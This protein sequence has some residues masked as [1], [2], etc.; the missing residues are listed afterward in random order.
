[1]V[2]NLQAVISIFR[3]DPR[4]YN[5]ISYLV[6]A[7]LLV[8]WAI[9]TLRHRPTPKT[10]SLALAAIAALSMLPIYHREYDTK[11]LLLTVPACAILWAEGGRIGRLALLVN[12]AGFVLTG[13]LPNAAF[14]GFLHFLHLPTTGLSGQ[15]LIAAQVFP[16]PLML[17][18]MGIFY[19]WAYARRCSTGDPLPT[20]AE[21]DWTSGNL[22]ESS[23]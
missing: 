2:V 22:K 7:P 11:L 12:S 8:A 6:C 23:A 13:D 3:D 4:V 17:L 5:P 9:Y 16:A 14:L 10:A 18:V 1:M 20:V 21:R 19:L 15:V